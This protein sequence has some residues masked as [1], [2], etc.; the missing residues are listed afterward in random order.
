MEYGILRREGYAER[1]IFIIDKMGIIRYIDIH[2]IDEQPD[3]EVLFKELEKLEPE[4]AAAYLQTQ[5]K[6]APASVPEP[7]A[8]VIMYCTPWCPECRMAR[9]YLS[10]NGIQWVEIDITRDKS[11]AE[12]VRGW[13]NGNEVTPTFNVKG[14]VIIG[15]DKRRLNKAL[16]LW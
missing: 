13:A 5:A 9:E 11:G 2:N 6:S 7:K 12:R 4:A 3:N 10:A 16:G 8:D 14:T 15:Y 1:A